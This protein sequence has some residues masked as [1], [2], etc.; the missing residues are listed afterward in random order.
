MLS[1]A[2]RVRV[3]GALLAMQR[4]SWDQGVTAAALQD[5]G[6]PDLL[7]VVLVDA[8]ARQLP[9]GRLGELQDVALVNSGAIGGVLHD[10]AV[11]TGDAEL[12][13]ASSR[14][15]AW[16][17]QHAPRAA[18]GTQFHLAGVREMWV[19]TVY[20]V[21]PA[22][23]RYGD[24]DGALAQY[25][26]HRARLRD[27]G[28]GLWR[29][30]YDEDDGRVVDP[31]AWGTGNGWVVM[32]L[33]RSIG[34]IGRDAQDELIADLASTL[35]ACLA[36]R[37]TDGLFGNHL[38]D[39]SSFA[40]ATGAAMFAYAALS[41]AVHGW[42]PDRYG[43]IGRNLLANV[44]STLDEYGRLSPACGAPSYDRP[45]Y[46]PEAQAAVLLADVAERRWVATR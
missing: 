45:G 1:G 44:T 9:D 6:R 26:G 7:H 35:D 28:T 43:E 42:L 36:L 20:M 5:L 32:A 31:R 17:R 19:D 14:Q 13:A 40:E 37:R 34:Q 12:R 4:H 2:A 24:H 3:L 29:H 22:L 8:V 10:E 18:D 46:S 27:P 33:A 39:P 41:A 30:R 38:D 25:R 11:R 23:A 15:E 16:L 21:V